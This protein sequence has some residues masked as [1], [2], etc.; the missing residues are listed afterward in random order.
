MPSRARSVSLWI[1]RAVQH[2]RGLPNQGVQ[3]VDPILDHGRGSE[4]FD[5]AQCLAF[6]RD[7]E[8][9][10]RDTD[11]PLDRK[12][13]GLLRS[14]GGPAPAR[15]K[16]ARAIVGAFAD[17]HA[18][19]SGCIGHGHPHGG[20][21]TSRSRPDPARTRVAART[22]SNRCGARLDVRKRTR[23]RAHRADQTCACSSPVKRDI[24]FGTRPVFLSMAYVDSLQ[25]YPSLPR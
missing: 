19:P 2:E 12:A 13:D 4:H 10:E 24:E 9:P 8:D 6:V 14:E 23:L 1:A 22:T 21:G 3:H 16:T 15:P 7:R 20:R 18:E 17:D 5:H 25:K 11:R